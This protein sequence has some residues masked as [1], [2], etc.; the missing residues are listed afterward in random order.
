MNKV[1]IVVLLFLVL[2][3]TGAAYSQSGTYEW[4][5][6]ITTVTNLVNVKTGEKRVLSSI[7][8][9][10]PAETEDEGLSH[11]VFWLG[12][13]LYLLIVANIIIGFLRHRKILPWKMS[14]HKRIGILILLVASA[15]AVIAIFFAG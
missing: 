6:N 12:I 14:V 15:H 2:W 10:L 5:T 3:I 11:I 7:D 13:T 1:L 4:V 9:V 8:R